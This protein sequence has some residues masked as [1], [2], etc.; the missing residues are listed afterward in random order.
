MCRSLWGLDDMHHGVLKELAV[1]VAKPLSII[2]E[3]S[4]HSKVSTDGKNG[5]ITLIFKKERMENLGN[6]SPVIPHLCA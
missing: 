4:W 6:F 2:Y 5:S 1:V 3:K